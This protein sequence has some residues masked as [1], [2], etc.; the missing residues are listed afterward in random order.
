MAAKATNGAE[1]VRELAKSGT[2]ER[3]LGVGRKVLADV[4]RDRH[5]IATCAE[6]I[7]ALEADEFTG[8]V[9]V[10]KARELAG[11]PAPKNVWAAASDLPIEAVLLGETAPVTLDAAAEKA[12]EKPADP[13]ARPGDDEDAPKP[14]EFVGPKKVIDPRPKK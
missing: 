11:L 12:P 2:G 4:W 8:E 14:P 1:L 5:R 10:A 6:V 7:E 13:P 3:K 9:T